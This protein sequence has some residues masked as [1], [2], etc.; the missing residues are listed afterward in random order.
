M[1]C[2]CYA[3]FSDLFLKWRNAVFMQETTHKRYSGPPPP[4][5]FLQGN[6]L[7]LGAGGGGGVGP[8]PCISIPRQ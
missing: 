5:Q 1:G 8:R 2:Y 3:V 7:L 4:T 6:Q